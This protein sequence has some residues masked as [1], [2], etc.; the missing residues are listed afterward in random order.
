MMVK[1]ILLFLLVM[2][3]L[4]V[5]GRLRFPRLPGRGSKGGPTALAKPEICPKCGRYQIGKAACDCQKPG[6]GPA[7]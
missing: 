2:A 1:V 6:N 4:A 7:E 5:F 3:A